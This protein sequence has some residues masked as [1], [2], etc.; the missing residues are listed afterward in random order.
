MTTDTVKLQIGMRLLR[1][2]LQLLPE[3]SWQRGAL[4]R[5]LSEFRQ[6]ERYQA[7]T[8]LMGESPIPFSKWRTEWAGITRVQRPMAPQR[9]TTTA[10][11]RA[12]MGEAVE[13]C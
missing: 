12:L 4:N 3:W 5:S 1:W 11:D 6:Y 10:R 8:L 13:R 9:S 2:A 7:L